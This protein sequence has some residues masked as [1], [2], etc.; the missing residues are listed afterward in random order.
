[1]NTVNI[2]EL[3]TRQQLRFLTARGVVTTEQLWEMPLTSKTGFDLDSL[4]KQ[5]NAE[6]KSVS[7][8][9]FV[10]TVTSPAK[11]E[12][13]LKLEIIKHVIAVKIEEN[14]ARLNKAKKAEERQKLIALLGKKQDA[15][16]ENL[17]E[18]EIKKQLAALDE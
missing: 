11:A 4:A 14:A 12:W 7:E 10:K 2:F 9:S 8:E 17:S 15:A 1:M 6:L 5:V 13:E 3:A 16:L 18:E